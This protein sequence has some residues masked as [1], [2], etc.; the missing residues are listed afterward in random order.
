MTQTQILVGTRKGAWVFADDGARGD[1]SLEGPMFLGQIVNHFVQDPR[2]ANVR[3]IAAKT[4][5]LG[6]TVFRSLDAGRTWT[7]A[8][9]PPAFPKAGNGQ[10]A[11]AVE[12]SFWL[13]PGHA[14]EPGVWWAG[15]SPPGLFVSEDNGRELGERHGLQRPCDVRQV[16][17][18]GFRHARRP[19]PEPDRDRPARRPHMYVATSTGGVFESLDRARSWAPLNK[20]VEATF[21]PDPFPEY[22]QDAHFIALRADPARPPLSAEPLRHLSSGPTGRRLGADRPRHAGGGRRHRLHHRAASARRGHRLG[23]SDGRNRRLAAGQPRRPAGG[24]SDRRRRRELAAA[25]RAGSRPRRAGSRSSGRRSAPTRSTPSGSIS[26]TT[27]GEVWISADEGEQLAADRRPPAGDL[28][29][30]R[31]AARMIRVLIPSQLHAYSGGQSRRGGRGGRPSRPCL[32]I[33]TAA[34]R[35]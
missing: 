35:A 34:S 2:D 9:R 23:L 16:G 33:S 32:T 10:T 15:T 5:H 30:G 8:R 1:W 21:L 25:G 13:E 27:G 20:G 19:A 29:G 4:G 28:F 3:L 7:E 14:S 22:G 17:P 6:P 11:R 24:L 18:G 26:G 31:N 12:H